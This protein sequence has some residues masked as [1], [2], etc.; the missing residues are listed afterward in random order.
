MSYN[1]NEKSTGL[2]VLT[3]LTLAQGD[4]H[5]VGD[6]SDSGRAKAITEEDLETYIANSTHFV[7]ELVGNTYFTDSLANDTN[8]LTELG[9]NVTVAV[10]GVTI[11]GD[12]TAGNPLVATGGGG[13][14][15]ITSINGNSTAAQVIAAG[16]GISV[17]SGSGT[18]TITNTDPGGITTSISDP[19][20]RDD[21]MS[22]SPS[23]I[24]K[25][26]NKEPDIAYNIGEMGWTAAFDVTGAGG[27]GTTNVTPISNV[28][29]HPGVFKL[30]S[31]N[32]ICS[33][34][35]LGGF[36]SSNSAPIDD[37]MQDNATYTFIVKP[38]AGGPAGTS[39]AHVGIGN[40]TT[41]AM[42]NNAIRV[43]FFDGDI[44]FQ[45]RDGSTTQSTNLGAYAAQFYKLE[46]SIS[47]AS[48]SL[49]VDGGAATTHSTHVPAAG[50]SGSAYFCSYY[51]FGIE[52]D[53]FS[54]YY[55]GLS[56]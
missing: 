17:V 39:L 7:D 43:L 38:D 14:G 16:A 56:R 49:S 15:G 45:T 20:F 25:G 11:V 13:G 3:E 34:V 32:S 52:G 23:I 40:F 18:T 22:V 6:V 33:Y 1:Q 46:I 47:G 30:I 9:G 12:G 36:T 44:I 5:I 4:L 53:F 54:M 28:T 35:K 41:D 10:D 24:I 21:F 50:S 2:D 37:I 42:A 19:F 27:G 31:A 51:N 26:T 55:P 29:G 8:F 48:V